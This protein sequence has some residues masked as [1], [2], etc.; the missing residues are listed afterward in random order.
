MGAPDIATGT[1][2]LVADLQV[3]R[4]VL[5][6]AHK[7]LLPNGTWQDG[8]IP[9]AAPNDEAKAAYYYVDG[10]AALA[11]AYVAWLSAAACGVCERPACMSC[12]CACSFHH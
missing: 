4:V 2:A 8:F 9:R 7:F 6:F 11:C 3:D 12:Q 1:G 10:C 5:E